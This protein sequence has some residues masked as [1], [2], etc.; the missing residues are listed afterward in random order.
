MQRYVN[1]ILAERL[2]GPPDETDLSIYG[3]PADLTGWPMP[4][5]GPHRV[6]VSPLLTDWFAAGAAALA[7]QFEAVAVAVAV[8]VAAAAEPVWSWSPDQSARFWL[9]MQTIEAA[10]HRCDAEAILGEPA[11]IA[12][13]LAADAVPQVFEV[14]APARRAWREAPPGEGE[15]YRFRRTDGPGDWLVHFDGPSV[16]LEQGASDDPAADVELAGSAEE[17]M[18]FLWQRRS[19]DGL[20]VHGE[21]GLL[22]RYFELVPPV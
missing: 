1:R 19:A 6:G 18:L 20:L 5:A 12:A 7:E 13:E 4:G 14:M 16:G 3:L 10:V 8:A 11:P 22:E 21:P 9:R 15:R 17:L 2:S